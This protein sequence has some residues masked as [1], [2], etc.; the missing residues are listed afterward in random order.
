MVVSKPLSKRNASLS[1]TDPLSEPSKLA[2]FPACGNTRLG[3]K[4]IGG[5]KLLLIQTVGGQAKLQ[6]RHAGGIELH[7][8]R[9]CVPR[10]SFALIS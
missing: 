6:H 2:G 4:R 7:D 3:E 8:H 9:V 10:T 5:E 1:K